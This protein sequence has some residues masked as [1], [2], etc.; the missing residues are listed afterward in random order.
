MSTILNYPR[1][2]INS[3][4][5]KLFI[6]HVQNRFS[7]IGSSKYKFVNEKLQIETK[8]IYLG[9]GQCL[10]GKDVYISNSKFNKMQKEL[11]YMSNILK[12]IKLRWKNNQ[13][14]SNSNLFYDASNISSKTIN[15]FKNKEIKHFMENCKVNYKNNYFDSSQDNYYILLKYKNGS[16]IQKRIDPLNDK[17]LKNSI[18]DFIEAN[19]SNGSNKYFPIFVMNKKQLDSIIKNPKFTYDLKSKIFTI[20]SS[21]FEILSSIKKNVIIPLNNDENKSLSNIIY[22]FDKDRSINQLKS[23]QVINRNSNN[24]NNLNNFNNAFSV[25]T[26]CENNFSI[27]PKVH[28]SVSGVDFIHIPYKNKFINDPNDNFYSSDSI[29]INN[30][31]D[32]EIID[33]LKQNVT[34]TNKIFKLDFG[35]TTP[36]NLLSGKF[37]IYSVSKWSKYCKLM[38]VNELVF[39]GNKKNKGVIYITKQKFNLNEFGISKFNL[40]ILFNKTKINAK[41]N[42]GNLNK[43]N[44]TNMNNI[45]MNFNNV[46]NSRLFNESS[47]VRPEPYD[48]SFR[49][50]GRIN[51][52]SNKNNSIIDNG[53]GYF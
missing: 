16:L 14:I 8:R 2:S 53:N 5:S 52:Y 4:S 37:L 20:T 17:E 46:T 29:T 48:G 43:D 49:N 7:I 40:L 11:D 38:K 10:L 12:Q 13:Q 26:T 23:K 15:F 24:L 3:K 45:S 32:L 36:L 33:N 31:S 27:I 50:E 44:N 9:T 30:N 34:K 18:I 42:E 6:H 21:K 25:S 22:T 35:Q 19:T 41:N 51:C 47:N 1:D 39:F 28:N